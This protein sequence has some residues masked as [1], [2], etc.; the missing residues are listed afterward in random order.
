[1]ACSLIPVVCVIVLSFQYFR[2]F[3]FRL[4]IA[5]SSSDSR[6]VSCVS[7]VVSGCVLREHPPT[8]LGRGYH[9]V[10]FACSAVILGQRPNISR[11][12]FTLSC[13]R[14]QSFSNLV[15]FIYFPSLKML[16]EE[17]LIER[18]M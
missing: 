8:Q 17:T 16:T 3:L 18:K 15:E 1:M 4:R 11:L 9:G 6:S 5:R 14:F 2:C 12:S 13:H 10:C 7:F